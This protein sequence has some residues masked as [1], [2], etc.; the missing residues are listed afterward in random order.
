M[1]AA[2][3]HNFGKILNELATSAPVI[4]GDFMRVRFERRKGGHP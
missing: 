1:K 2:R 3:I 4:T